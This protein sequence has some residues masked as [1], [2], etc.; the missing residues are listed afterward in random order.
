[1]AL[2]LFSACKPKKA[3]MP[4]PKIHGEEVTY[5]AD[6]ITM[7]GYIAWDE[8]KQ[9]KRP[10]ILVVHEWWGHNPY[11]RHR[12]DML[13]EL[14]Y[15]ALAVDMYGN[16]KVADHPKDAGM[17]AGEVMKRGPGA[18]VRFMKAMEVLK[19]N[20]NV[21]TNNIGAIGYCFGG[22]TVLNMARQGLDLKAVVSFHGGLGTSTPAKKG[23][24]KA[25]LLVCNGGA[26]KFVPQIDIDGFKKEMDDAGVTYTFKSYDGALHSFSNPDADALGKKFDMAIA[27]NAAAD[28]ASWADMKAFFGENMK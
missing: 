18:A 20:P 14:G 4:K 24:V 28:S 1:M 19:S 25:K 22:S 12:A 23:E 15:V 3:E 11:A 17:F 6:S 8:Q 5:S 9:G 21:D 26:D 7:K 13:A 10:G 16:G 2:V 27:Y